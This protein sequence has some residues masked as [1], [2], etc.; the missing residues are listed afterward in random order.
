MAYLTGL[1]E[2][3][4]DDESAHPGYVCRLGE[5][6]RGDSKWDSNVDGADQHSVV[7]V[8]MVP[9]NGRPYPISLASI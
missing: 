1:E 5:N 6:G 9:G 3:Q 2:T 4:A 7:V 8:G